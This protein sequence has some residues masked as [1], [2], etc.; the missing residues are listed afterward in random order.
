MNRT[1]SHHMLPLPYEGKDFP[2]KVGQCSSW[3][4]GQCSSWLEGH[5]TH[6]L[7]QSQDLECLT[8]ERPAFK[9]QGDFT[10]S[11]TTILPDY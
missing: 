4:E 1:P 10:C 2:R 5:F 3:L 7:G 8:S 11:F 9:V 6:H